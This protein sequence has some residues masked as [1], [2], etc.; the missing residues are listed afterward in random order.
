M[1]A[2]SGSLEWERGC[3][4]FVTA[5]RSYK[6]KGRDEIA[7]NMAAIRSKENR[8]EAALRK[9]LHRLG[10][11]YR[12]Y[13][14]DLPGKPDFVFIRERVAVFVDGDYWHGRTLREN[15]A[16]P[17]RARLKTE[18]RDYWLTKLARTC[19]RDDAANAALTSAGWHVLRFWES[20][21]KGQV[22]EVAQRIAAFVNQLRRNPQPPKQPTRPSEFWTPL[23]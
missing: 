1:I 9:Q 10:L 15:G 13:P 23:E 16:G 14:P 7:R 21:V 3:G 11:R 17:M 5:G 8:T 18:N 22:S 20:E 2:S 6:P 12:K 4:S 19:A